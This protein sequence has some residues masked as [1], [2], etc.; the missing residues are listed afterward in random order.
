MI[1]GLYLP[2][3]YILLKYTYHFM[4]HFIFLVSKF[5]ISRLN[6]FHFSTKS[7]I[8]FVFNLYVSVSYSF[9][10]TGINSPPLLQDF[11]GSW[12]P[13]SGWVRRGARNGMR[14]EKAAGHRNQVTMSRWIPLYLRIFP[15]RALDQKPYLKQE[16]CF[17]QQIVKAVFP[18]T[19]G[20]CSHPQSHFSGAAG[21][22][23]SG[24]WPWESLPWAPLSLV[25]ANEPEAPLKRQDPA[26]R[27]LIPFV[28]MRAVHKKSLFSL[29]L[30]SFFSFLLY[31]RPINLIIWSLLL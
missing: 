12:I 7:L 5:K 15:A 10:F 2:Q 21:T 1:C 22:A 26:D 29:R 30:G 17:S 8:S 20:L 14:H 11:S 24:P 3:N 27:G 31:Y 6:I 28:C 18:I 13:A 9:F 4:W 19:D 23:H 16:L 25:T